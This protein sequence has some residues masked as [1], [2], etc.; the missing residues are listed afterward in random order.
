MN[1]KDYE[2]TLAR[3]I[4][5]ID[6]EYPYV[7]ENGQYKTYCPYCQKYNV[8]SPAE[9]KK[10][11]QEKKCPL[12]GN[13]FK[14]TTRT[15]LHK[16]Y[17]DAVFITEDGVDNGY[18]VISEWSFGDSVKLKSIDKYCIKQGH[19]LLVKKGYYLSGFYYSYRI[20]CYPNEVEDVWHKSRSM[21]YY[22]ASYDYYTKWTFDFGTRKDRTKILNEIALLNKSN[23]IKLVLEN[24]LTIDMAKAVK[25]FDINTIEQVKQYE[26]YLKDNATH[27]ED[28]IKNNMQLNVHYLDYLSRKNIDLG[29][30]FV[31]LNDLKKLGFP[32]EKPS[33]FDFRSQKVGEM[34]CSVADKVINDKISNRLLTLPSYSS[35]NVIIK[36]FTT[37]YE[38]RRCGKVLHNCIGGY[39]TRY[40]DGETD[41][42]HLN[43]DGVLK[44]AIEIK[45][46]KL[47]QAYADHNKP[48]PADLMKHIKSFCNSNGFSLGNYA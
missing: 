4:T 12:C 25:V 18:Y 42:Y 29:S 2:Q 47:L 15:H 35:D 39:T 20:G 13:S 26:Q 1:I 37:A 40:G 14:N 10:V 44:I 19:N 11:R 32:Y 21:N 16:Y 8:L 45:D 33:D 31:F 34:A 36:P 30:Y 17:G 5:S 38:V 48:C 3:L 41:L 46:R 22:Y 43:L 28:F 24:N 9:F 7:K 27:V 6:K 23:Q